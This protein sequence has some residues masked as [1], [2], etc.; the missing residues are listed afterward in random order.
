[1]NIKA[2]ELRIGN[3][4]R[5]KDRRY[6][7][8]VTSGTFSFIETNKD[9]C[10]GIELTVKWL[11]LLGFERINFSGDTKDDYWGH[12]DLPKEY[13]FYLPYNHF[14]LYAGN[15]TIKYVH[16][17]QNLFFALTQKELY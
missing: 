14:S 12:T 6:E 17:L 16:E 5:E 4:I 15:V 7:F 9:F 2:N 11:K 1:M 3:F 10:E 8:Q 13:S